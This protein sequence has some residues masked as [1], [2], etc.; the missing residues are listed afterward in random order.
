MQS[1]TASAIGCCA[2][3]NARA[4]PARLT[5]PPS[6]SSV[7]GSRSPSSRNTLRRDT[8][9]IT[10]KNA[11]TTPDQVRSMT[12]SITSRSDRMSSRKA[13][14]TESISRSCVMPPIAV[15]TSPSFASRMPFATNETST[16]TSRMAMGHPNATGRQRTSGFTSRATMRA[17]STI[18]STSRYGSSWNGSGIGIAYR[19]AGTNMITAVSATIAALHVKTDRRRST[20][21]ARIPRAAPATSGGSST[22]AADGSRAASTTAAIDHAPPARASG[23]GCARSLARGGRLVDGRSVGGPQ[24]AVGNGHGD[25]SVRPGSG[26]DEH[27]V[28]GVVGRRADGRIDSGSIASLSTGVLGADASTRLGALRTT[29]PEAREDEGQGDEREEH[30]ERP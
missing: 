11:T 28:V 16:V 29:R 6:R 3:P 8:R 30:R 19:R 20:S 18:T 14:K 17:T 27:V 9:S 2:E 22:T 4:T 13:K 1:A 25:R 10:A 24:H 7:R 15:S 26:A 21:R 5:S 12:S 23:P